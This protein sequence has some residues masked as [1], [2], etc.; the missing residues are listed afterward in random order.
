M[1]AILSSDESYSIIQPVRNQFRRHTSIG[2]MFMAAAGHSV[3]LVQ[4]KTAP[5]AGNNKVNQLVARSIFLSEIWVCFPTE[6]SSQTLLL[7]GGGWQVAVC[8][9]DPLPRRRQR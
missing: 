7:T 4:A 1:L 9:S 3:G 2:I 8:C 6:S 5:R